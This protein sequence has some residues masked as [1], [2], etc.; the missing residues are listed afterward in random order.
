MDMILA[1]DTFEDANV[2]CVTD[3]GEKGAASLLDFTL[4]H[5]VALFGDPYHMHGQARHCMAAMAVTFHGSPSS[6]ECR[7]VEQ[8]KS[9]PE[10]A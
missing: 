3:V 8:L 5:M 6:H 2:L 1:H 10:S 4:E 7:R 9:C